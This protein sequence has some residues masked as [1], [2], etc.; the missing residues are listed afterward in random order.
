[1]RPEAMGT[2]ERRREGAAAEGSDERY[3]KR[4]TSRL[5]RERRVS[6][7][8]EGGEEQGLKVGTMWRVEP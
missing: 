5:E 2:K 7:K 6:R 1:M 4:E 3:K 8:G